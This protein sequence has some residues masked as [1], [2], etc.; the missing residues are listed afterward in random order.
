M[1]SNIFE[2]RNKYKLICDTYSKLDNNEKLIIRTLL[3][4]NFSFGDTIFITE[5]DEETL[6]K[7]Y[8]A[9]Q[10][11][12]TGSNELIDFKMEE[13]D[14]PKVSE[15][16]G[17]DYPE[18]DGVTSANKKKRKPID[19]KKAIEYVIMKL[20]EHNFN[21]EII[22]V[23]RG[24]IKANIGNKPV[25]IKVVASKDWSD[26]VGVYTS[27]SRDNLKEIGN[28]DFNIYI[29]EGKDGVY[30]SL[31]FNKEEMKSFLNNKTSINWDSS[32]A[33]FSF[34]FIGE[35]VFDD[36]DKPSQDV[37]FAEADNI[38]KWALQ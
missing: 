32:N 4:T 17:I 11:V 3:L 30:K 14:G 5:A 16:Y 18:E 26:E 34:K 23:R 33:F 7:C 15:D 35:K 38:K 31:L 27:W 37:S 22:N 25:V 28:Y 24:I 12:L 19:V 8:K 20:K 29:I 21:L 2:L 1:D 6:D 10:N 9:V 13:S 36:R